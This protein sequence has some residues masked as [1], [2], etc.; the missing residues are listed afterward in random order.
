MYTAAPPKKVMVE[1]S[2]DAENMGQYKENE[3]KELQERID[4]F[5]KKE[6]TEFKD[7]DIKYVEL[8]QKVKS[9]GIFLSSELHFYDMETM[10]TRMEKHSFAPNPMPVKKYRD[11]LLKNIDNFNPKQKVQPKKL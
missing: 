1:G 11:E 8:K 10:K 5:V 4:K 7:Y 6:L 2:T 3:K 9:K